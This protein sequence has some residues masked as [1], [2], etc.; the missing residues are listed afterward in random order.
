MFSTT[1]SQRPR[2]AKARSTERTRD[3][4]RKRIQRRAE[5]VIYIPACE[6]RQRREQL[7]QDDAAWLLYYFA[8]EACPKDPFSYRFVADQIAM[9]DALR[10]AILEGGDQAVAA[11]R[12]S[13]KTTIF[14]RQ[15]T[16][17]TLQGLIK[18]SVLFAAS[19]DLAAA[20]LDSIKEQLEQ[21]DRLLADYPEACYPIRALENTPN[22][23]HYQRATGLRHDNGEP[24]EAAAT[25]FSWSG[26]EIVLPRTPGSPSSE[27]IIATRGLDSA[28]R[29][30]K[31]KGRRVDVAGIDDPDTEETSRSEHQAEKLLQRIDRGIAGLGSQR[32][33]VARVI[34]TTIQSRISASYHVIH[35]KPS[36]HGQRFQFLVTP[37]EHADLWQNFIEQRHAD[38]RHNTN[39][40]HE[41]YLAHREEMDA[42]AVVGNP[43]RFTAG[44]HFLP[45]G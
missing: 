34:L 24:Y 42:G 36:F 25:K 1:T 39:T 13:G 37:P 22:R 27:A 35:N 14:E 18:F 11:P 10:R 30:I 44:V 21:N 12:G 19:G 29:G 38:Y 31:R 6:D 17:Y 15:L 32:R 26:Q 16:K 4:N 28:V 41:F 5:S 43:H 7:E 45:V 20:S 40:A 23:A 2:R 9:I 33:T 3:A 8:P